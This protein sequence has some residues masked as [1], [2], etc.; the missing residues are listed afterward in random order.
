MDHVHHKQNQLN[1]STRGQWNL[2]STHRQELERLIVP[3]RPGLRICVLG[4][5][6]CN[7]LDLRWLVEAYREVH[8]VDI[9]ATALEHAVEFQKV[10]DSPRVH[11]H[12]GVDL[13]GLAGRMSGWIKT[14]PS[15]DEVQQCTAAAF[16]VRLT[17]QSP[18]GLAA[19]PKAIS[20]LAQSLS[21]PFDVVLS[22]C[23]L[24]QLITPARDSIGESHPG[25]DSLL[26]ALRA[27]HVSLMLDLLAPKG[28]GVLACD[29]FSS[30]TVDDL[31]RVPKEQARDLMRKMLSAGKYFSGLDPGSIGHVLKA[32]RAI[33]PRIESIEPAPPW[34]WHLGLSKSYLVYAILIRRKG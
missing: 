3:E 20:P 7:D 4:A 22:P 27:A 16:P 13:T 5:G 34:V 33:A 21:G 31:A 12:G 6:N 26:A 19:E 25:F 28:K 11:L 24:S 2:Y 32:D 8:L 10:H 17:G 14:P 1:R 30:A 9:D 18:S 29:L 23:V 15:S